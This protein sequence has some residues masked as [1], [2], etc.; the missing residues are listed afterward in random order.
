MLFEKTD[1]KPKIE[2][3]LNNT[4]NV[5]YLGADIRTRNL[6]KFI[7]PELRKNWEKCILLKKNKFVEVYYNK[8]DKQISY[9][10]VYDKDIFNNNLDK[11]VGI[12]FRIF[13]HFPTKYLNQILSILPAIVLDSSLNNKKIIMKNTH[14]SK[15]FWHNEMLNVITNGYKYKLSKIYLNVLEK[16][17]DITFNKKKIYNTEYILNELY[18]GLSKKYARRSKDSLY[19]KIKF[20]SDIE[21]INFNKIAWFEIINKFFKNNPNMIRH[22]LYNENNI[23]NSKLLEILGDKYEY[24]I[25]RIKDYINNVKNNYYNK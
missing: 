2:E 9:E 20:N 21:F 13:D 23:N 19:R 14:V 18:L 7:Y 11:R 24:D 4:Y 5:M 10:R 6:D 12:E 16:E 1:I 8:L 15:Q 22:I 3:V 17:F 25:N